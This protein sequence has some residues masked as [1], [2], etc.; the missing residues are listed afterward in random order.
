MRIRTLTA[1]ALA[2]GTLATAGL[3]GA[4]DAQAVRRD[5]TVQD[6][7][8][9]GGFPGLTDDTDLESP[10]VLWVCV[11]GT[12]NGQHITDMNGDGRLGRS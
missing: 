1:L 5:V 8:T 6:C 10:D 3:F 12:H 7:V 11:G 9:G 4:S 2:A